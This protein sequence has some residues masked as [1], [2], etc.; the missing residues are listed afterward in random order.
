MISGFGRSV[1]EIG[2]TAGCCTECAV[3][4]D[5]IAQ[6]CCTEG[7]VC[8]DDIAQ[9]YINVHSG[10]CYYY[11][12]IFTNPKSSR[13]IFEQCSNILFHEKPLSGSRVVSC[14]RTD[15]TKLG[16]VFRNVSNA[17]QSNV[18]PE[19]VNVNGV[20]APIFLNLAMRR[21]SPEKE[22]TVTTEPEAGRNP[23][24]IW[25]FRYRR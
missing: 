4:A 10:S 7:A 23:E 6:G 21:L 24:Q 1:A 16:V 22:R 13:Q 17:P 3:C 18:V 12:Q 2:A 8:S 11:H 19:G 14:R 20:I 5:D 15:K 25:S 9:G